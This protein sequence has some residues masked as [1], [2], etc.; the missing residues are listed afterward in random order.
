MLAHSAWNDADD[1]ALEVHDERVNGDADDDY[2]D[3]DVYVLCKQ[4][5]L[6]ETTYTFI[7]F[8]QT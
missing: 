4:S 5:N 3:D 1:T 2:N 7:S 6:K 8:T